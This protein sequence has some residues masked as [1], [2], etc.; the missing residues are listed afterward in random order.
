MLQYFWTEIK[1][2]PEG[3]LYCK[4]QNITRTKF[5]KQEASNFTEQVLKTKQRIFEA[6]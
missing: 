4:G 5:C 2:S 6:L 3:I 1:L